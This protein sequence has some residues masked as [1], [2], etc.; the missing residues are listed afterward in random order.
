MFTNFLPATNEIK[1]YVS[2]FTI[3]V[4]EGLFPVRYTAFPNVGN[5]LAFFNHTAIKIKLD[6]IRFRKNELSISYKLRDKIH[7]NF[8]HCF[9]FGQSFQYIF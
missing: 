6:E 8:Y 4:E 5:C 3:T 2:S 1:R 7:F 9:M